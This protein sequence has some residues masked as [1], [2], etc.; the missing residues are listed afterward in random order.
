MPPIR[1]ESESGI[2]PNYLVIGGQRC[3]SSWIHKCLD[4]H[5]QVFTANPKEL[6]FFNR[7]FENGVPW[8][9]NHFHPSLDHLAWG[10]VT[11]DYIADN[12]SPRR[13]A[14]VCPD[15]KLVLIMREPIER[16]YSI[17]R[18]KMGTSL[19]YPTFEEAISNHPEI[20][21]HGL[22]F[23]HITNWYRYF[24]PDQFLFLT[25]ND[26]IHSDQQ[27]ISKIFRH[28][29][30]DDQFVPTW[31]GKPLNTAVLPK[32]RAQLKSVGLDPVIK[33]VG[34]SPVGDMI[35]RRVKANKKSS[36]PLSRISGPTVH[37]LKEYYRE[38][39]NQLR[40]LLKTGLEGWS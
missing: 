24:S 6:H 18:L 14:E 23:K 26:L 39:N 16:A 37:R 9:L 10:E 8:Y 22:Y 1:T 2:P 5:P 12:E 40:E 35:R 7:H 36:D 11:P 30:V 13:A 21:E 17:Y 27:T 28:I 29:M 4:E 25:Y 3:G 20:L 15:A 31:I 34:R 33:A 19:N 32:L 38:P